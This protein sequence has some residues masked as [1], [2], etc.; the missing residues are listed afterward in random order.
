MA[1]HLLVY[2]VDMCVCFG[3]LVRYRGF[4]SKLCDRQMDNQEPVLVATK[5]SKGPQFN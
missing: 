5:Q 4:G 1:G 3:T 2:P